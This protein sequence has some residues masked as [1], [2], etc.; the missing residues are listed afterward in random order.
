MRFFYFPPTYNLC[1][2]K[3]LLRLSSV[4]DDICAYMATFVYGEIVFICQKHS[5]SL[6]FLHQKC[7]HLKNDV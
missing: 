5:K 7:A 2:K 4:L 1:K 6:S 3:L